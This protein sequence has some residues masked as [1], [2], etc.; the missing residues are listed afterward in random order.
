MIK[1]LAMGFVLFLGFI[2]GIL[3]M[4]YGWGLIPMSWGWII[5]GYFISIFLL[6]LMKA[7]E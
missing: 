5:S 6:I 3:V 2:V 4:I 1:I 7:I